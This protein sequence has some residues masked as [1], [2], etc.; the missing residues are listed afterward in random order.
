[1][2]AEVYFFLMKKIFLPSFF[3]LGALTLSDA[4]SGT[5]DGTYNF[6]LLGADNS[7]GPGYKTLGDKFIVPNKATEGSDDAIYVNNST[8]GSSASIEIRAEGGSVCKHFTLKNLTFS[9]AASTASLNQFSITLKNAS[10]DV[11]VSHTLIGTQALSTSDFLLLAFNFSTAFPAAGYDNVSEIDISWKYSAS[12]PNELLFKSI[13]IANVDANPTNVAPTDISL[14][15]S[16]VNENVVPNTVVGSISA[17]DSNPGDSFTYTL[18]SGTGDTDNASFHISADKLRINNSPDFETKNSYSIRLKVTDQGGLTYEEVFAI[19]IVDVAEAVLPEVVTSIPGAIA[20][21]TAMLGGN[22]SSDG[23][24]TVTQRGIV[25]NTTG[26][27]TTSSTKVIIGS[28]T[29]IFSRNVTGLTPETTYYTRAYAINAAGTAYGSEQSFTTTNVTLAPEVDVVGNGSSIANGDDTPSVADHT[30]FGATSLGIAVTRTFT[31]KNTGNTDLEFTEGIVLTGTSEDFQLSSVPFITVL[32]PGGS[33][34]FE[35]TFSPNVAGAH[36][37]VVVISTNDQNEGVY[38]F[39]LQGMGISEITTAISSA[40]VSPTNNNPIPVEIDFSE[41][42]L[43]FD[44]QDIIVNG[45]VALNFTGSGSQYTV[46]IVPFANGIFTVDVPA[47]VATNGFAIE[48][49]AAPQF[50]M[51]YDGESP[52]L[53][54]SST[55]GTHTNA[56]IIPVL[57]TF[58]ENV[59]GFDITDLVVTSA[60]V[61]NFAG[62]GTSY[63]VDVVPNENGTITLNILSGAGFDAAGNGNAPSLFTLEY[64]IV[65]PTI[66]LTTSKPGPTSENPIPISINFSEPVTG[67]TISD[68]TITG[69]T[70]STLQGSETSYSVMIIPTI[71]EGII[72]VTIA[73]SVAEDLAGNGNLPASFNVEYK[74]PCA[75]A[76][77]K[78]SA[79]QTVFEG[80]EAAPLLS[81]VDASGNV[82]FAYQWE[83]SSDGIVFTPI[84]GAIAEQYSPGKLNS[85]RR[86][87]RRVYFERCG[88]ATSN[89][90]SITV[91]ARPFIEGEIPNVLF[92]YGSEINRTWGISHFNFTDNVMIKIF[93]ITGRMLFTTTDPSQEWNGQYQGKFVSEGVYYYVISGPQGQELKGSIEVVY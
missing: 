27:P 40:S 73:A 59:T 85:T 17:T 1:M 41:P 57:I 38:T 93:D 52:T 10:G 26:A 83:E 42:V 22:V 65:R 61:Q 36:S 5:S 90:V 60:T 3:F 34:E 13:T 4:Q 69:G 92:P 44:I 9:N 74:F 63:T 45:G 6:S 53:T 79:D 18:V 32:D 23:G 87:R 14:S 75:V 58:T 91:E 47:G 15:A 24:G 80:S 50:I 39:E 29:G 71:P 88:D 2:V 11:I 67:F 49:S 30:D 89:I 37:I 68:I 33:M 19:T 43:Q 12:A 86:F 54:M 25:Y 55:V 64:D 35:V 78:I 77:G 8:L 82:M 51:T 56:T 84:A 20:N 7:A 21:T 48:N 76:P 62:S 16:S 70:A 31:I 72:Q 28:G 46:D 66:T 81:D